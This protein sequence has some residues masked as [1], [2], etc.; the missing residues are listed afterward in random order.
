MCK[1]EISTA[2]ESPTFAVNTCDGV[3]TATSAQA[4]LVKLRS[5][6]LSERSANVFFSTAER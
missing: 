1:C 4:L 2:R 3:T 6:N 5:S